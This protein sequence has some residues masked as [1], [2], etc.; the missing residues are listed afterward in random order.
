VKSVP[1]VI[2][3]DFR[4]SASPDT[5]LKF[6]NR[7]AALQ[8][9]F[10]ACTAPVEDEK[11]HRPFYINDTAVVRRQYTR[12]VQNLPGI[13]PFYAVKCNPDRVLMRSLA[14][15]GAGFDCASAAEIDAALKA[16]V[17]PDSIIFAN[18]VK[19]AES[20]RHAARRG[21]RLMTFDNAD[22]LDKIAQNHPDAELVLRILADDS[23]SL[24]RFGS[25]FGAP[26]D[27]VESLFR[28]AKQLNLN[29]V[30]IAFHIGSGCLGRRLRLRF[31]R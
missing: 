29:V 12:W 10:A 11:H 8:T 17:G 7:E 26:F 25:K 4:L 27:M 21:V 16:G 18:P 6:P 31:C 15:L 19:S 22:E 1:R 5:V 23:H 24:M 14:E 30:G 20:L 28:R 13:R 9:V 3:P 2:S